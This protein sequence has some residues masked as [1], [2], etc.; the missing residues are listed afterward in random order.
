MVEAK[1]MFVF[2]TKSNIIPIDVFGMTILP[3]ILE[4]NHLKANGVETNIY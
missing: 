2:G 4:T 1:M 3:Q